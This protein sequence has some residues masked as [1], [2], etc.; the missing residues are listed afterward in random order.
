MGAEPNNNWQT[1]AAS[2]ISWWIDAGVDVLV[3]EDVRDWTARPQ[4]PNAV[5]SAPAIAGGEPGIETSAETLPDTLDSFLAWRMSAAAPEAGWHAEFV[6]PV[7]VPNARLMVVT[8]MPNPDDA[9]AGAFF[10]E[11]EGMLFDAILSAIGLDRAHVSIASLAVARHATGTIPAETEQ[12]FARLMRRH[13]ALA[14]P[15]KLLVLGDATARILSGATGGLPDG[16]SD[17]EP[18]RVAMIRHPRFL[19]RRPA[20]K[21]EAWR[22]LQILLTEGQSR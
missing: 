20:A 12:L 21:A 15:E 1:A 8:D 10:Q 14:R 4:R 11:R 13:I 19:L 6:A 2:A 16:N 3:E 7:S 9:R 22:K 5:T 17:Y 18:S